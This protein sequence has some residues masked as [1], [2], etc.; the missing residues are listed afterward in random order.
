MIMNAQL[1]QMGLAEN[2]LEP[3][4]IHLKVYQKIFLIGID[5]ATKKI[6][7]ESFKLASYTLESYESSGEKFH[8]CVS[9]LKQ[10]NLNLLFIFKNKGNSHSYLFL[11]DF[12][13]RV[14]NF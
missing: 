11:R 7:A 13:E 12:K 9:I 3:S 10:R 8:L 2:K 14:H 1:F 6:L 5:S 4:L